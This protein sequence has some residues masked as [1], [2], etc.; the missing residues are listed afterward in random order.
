MRYL[1]NPVVRLIARSPLDRWTGDLVVLRFTGHRSGCARSIPALAHPVGGRPHV[2][3][4]APWAQ[5]FRDGRAVVVRTR[6]HSQPCTGR[7]LPDAEAV[8]ALRE[9]LRRGSPRLLGL[10]LPAGAQPSDAELAALRRAIR[11]DP[12]S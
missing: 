12:R 5:N 2:F 4:D 10:H 8:V 7:L 1:V 3:T 9:V 11:L 6:G